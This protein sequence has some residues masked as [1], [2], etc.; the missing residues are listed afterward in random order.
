MG[1]GVFFIFYIN[2]RPI[3]LTKYT[4]TFAHAHSLNRSVF[5]GK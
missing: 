3:S 5:I 2:A 1:G 4:Y